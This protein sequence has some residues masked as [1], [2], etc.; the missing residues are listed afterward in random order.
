MT[1]K[2]IAIGDSITYAEHLPREAAWTTLL[3]LALDEPVLNAGVCADTTR[4]GLER[5]PTDVQ[6]HFPERVV[7]QF[8]HNDCN[9][10]KTDRGMRRVSP[11]AYQANLIEMVDRARRFHA[12][13]IVIVNLHPT[14][15]G[16]KY[17]HDRKLYSTIAADV[18][19]ETG[20]LLL[21]VDKLLRERLDEVL[22]DEIHLNGLGNQLVADALYAVLREAKTSTS[23]RA[24]P[25]L[26]AAQTAAHGRVHALN[27]D[28]GDDCTCEHV[29]IGVTA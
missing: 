19:R 26:E 22:L 11:W 3:A 17:E 20:V 24:D 25:P 21:D 1:F 4:L 7:V 10:W 12:E 9:R 18:A 8:G 15:K 14:T 23:D 6:Q 28:M 16:R 2:T 5:F 27:C 13:Q 29:S